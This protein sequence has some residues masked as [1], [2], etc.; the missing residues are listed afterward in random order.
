MGFTKTIHDTRGFSLCRTKKSNAQNNNIFCLCSGVCKIR[1]FNSSRSRL[2]RWLYVITTKK[3]DIKS[4]GYD[5]IPNN[6]E[7][8]RTVRDV[9]AK[10]LN[11]T[12]DL[13]EYGDVAIITEVLEHLEDPHTFIKNLSSKFLVASSP[14]NE[15]DK[16][17]RKFHIWAWDEE[18]YQKM[19]ND[20]GYTIIKNTTVSGWSQ[21]VLAVKTEK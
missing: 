2:R 1:C 6:V 21:I 4:W 11:I 7:Y 17:H 9:D 20:N 19:I 18:G 12:N 8:A 14:Y 13:L 15:T 5:L 3:K 10:L 16:V